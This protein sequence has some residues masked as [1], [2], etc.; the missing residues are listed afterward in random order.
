MFMG[1]NRDYG[2]LAEKKFISMLNFYNIPYEYL[3]GEIDFTIYNIPIDVKST[4]LSHKF[5]DR[6]SNTQK[7]KI[8]RFD[9]TARQRNKN[10]YL[11]LFVRN[12]DNFLFLG[13]TKIDETTH[14]YISIHK[15]RELKVYTLKAF[16][17]KIRSEGI[18]NQKRFS[19]PLR[20]IT[21]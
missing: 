5:T 9:I 8:G 12:D 16:I 19:E 2:T 13:I 6:K 17:R 14:R 7:Y 11:A 18:E 3:N 20:G 21:K 15:L 10:C 4:L 1:E